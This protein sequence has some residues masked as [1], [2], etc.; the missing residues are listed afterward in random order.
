MKYKITIENSV[1]SQS[2]SA[3]SVRWA[4]P[5]LSSQGI[6]KVADFG[7]GRFRN[8]NVLTRY[9]DEVFF[10]ETK[11]QLRKFSSVA[12]QGNH[13]HYIITDQFQ[14]LTDHFDAVFLISVLHTIPHKTHRA[15]IIRLCHQSLKPGGLLVVDVPQSETY[16]NRRKNVSAKYKDG[17]LMKWGDGYTFYKNFYAA[18]LDDFVFKQKFSLKQKTWIIKHLTRI[19]LKAA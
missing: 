5:I 14:N 1:P 17:W 16:Y 4:S 3:H 6:K 18:E 19:Y 7:S 13:V 15:K 9:F 12:P 8:A 2:R 11:K 10:V